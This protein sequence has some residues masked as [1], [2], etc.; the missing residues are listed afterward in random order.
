MLG[1]TLGLFG[2]FPTLVV[3]HQGS[4][5]ATFRDWLWELVSPRI[6]ASP[7]TLW[8][9]LPTC[10]GS[11]WVCCKLGNAPVIRSGTGSWVLSDKSGACHPLSPGIRL[12]L[13][14]SRKKERKKK[15]KHTQSI[16]QSH[17]SHIISLVWY[18]GWVFKT[19]KRK[20]DRQTLSINNHSNSSIHSQH[21]NTS[22]S[23]QHSCVQ[24]PLQECLR[25]RRFQ[26]ALLLHLHLCTFLM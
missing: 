18:F 22:T 4:L 5:G 14:K 3:G 24:G 15:T 6:H 13:R 9:I 7:P 26:A 8:S 12:G 23:K 2:A 10:W 11:A 25:A 16:N 1:R 20:K 19:H 21:T 17:T